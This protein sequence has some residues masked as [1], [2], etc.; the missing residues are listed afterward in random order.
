M[1]SIHDA[2][3]ALVAAHGIRAVVQAL[4]VLC[5]WKAHH[6]RSAGGDRALAD[7]WERAGTTLG[8]DAQITLRDLA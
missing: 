6:L 5:R 3:G 4:S 2:L 8:W 7:A 1:D